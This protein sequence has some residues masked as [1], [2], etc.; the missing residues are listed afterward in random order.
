MECKKRKLHESILSASL[1][2]VNP[3]DHGVL[4]S[5]QLIPILEDEVAAESVALVAVYADQISERKS[6]SRLIQELNI[7]CPIP[8]LHH[9]KRASKS[10]VILNLVGNDTPESCVQNL[11][12]RGLNVTG[13]SCSPQKML[14]PAIA[15]RTRRQFQE[16]TKSWPC[17]FHED[18]YLEK[19]LRGELFTAM[20]LLMHQNYMSRCL[21]AAKLSVSAGGAGVGAL[22]VD[23]GSKQV[24]AVG[25]DDRGNHS[26]QHAVM[27]VVDL[28][29]RSQGGGAWLLRDG[30]WHL[31][32]ET[33]HK[34]EVLHE[35]KRTKIESINVKL[36]KHCTEKLGEENISKENVADESTASQDSKTG[37]Y[38]C[39]GY[40]VYVT[41]E[42]CAMC[43]MALVHS[44]AKRIF[45][46][47]ASTDGAL[48]TKTKLHTLNALNHHYEVFSG[49]LEEEC[50][51][52]QNVLTI[53]N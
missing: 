26:L 43:A 9:L 1:E 40:E 45:Y 7:V 35:H 32:I 42:P 38:L 2:S 11:I 3:G 19:M 5:W 8:S 52:V 25:Y 17:N 4:K 22:V 51:E 34:D 29:A 49:I 46:G 10:G 12:A 13:L 16:A 6:T 18:K 48:G 20:E 33:S 37:P 53:K 30:Q 47:C 24:I 21:E 14:V 23:P 27:V 50:Q 15:P 44:R 39:T 41:R 28:V 36:I 31:G